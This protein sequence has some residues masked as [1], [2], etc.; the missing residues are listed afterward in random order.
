MSTAAQGAT[1]EFVP[2]TPCELGAGLDYWTELQNRIAQ[3]AYQ[4]FENRGKAHGHD[5]EDWLSAERE[6]L[7]SLPVH[8]KDAEHLYTVTANVSG[9]VA[10]ELEVRA[11]PFLIL[12]I[13]RKKESAGEYLAT[14]AGEICRPVD[15]ADEIETNTVIAELS[16]GELTISMR[17]APIP[18]IIEQPRQKSK[19]LDK[20]SARMHKDTDM[21]QSVM[22]AAA[23]DQL[24]RATAPTKRVHAQTIT[25]RRKAREQSEHQLRIVD[26]SVAWTEE[27]PHSSV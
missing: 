1:V 18:A 5:V 23:K 16:N 8:I 2:V 6:I 22:R 10:N 4:I 19:S 26:P 17:K 20:R 27:V 13:G 25:R 9:F 21:S 12:I 3:R 7:H 24:R 14:K 15:L 11:E